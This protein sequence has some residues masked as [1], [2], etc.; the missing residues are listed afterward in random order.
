MAAIESKR[1]VSLA[2]AAVRKTSNRK[3]VPPSLRYTTAKHGKTTVRRYPGRTFYKIEEIKGKTIDL[4]EVFLCAE[5]HVID[6]RFDD[7]TSLSF[8]I[9]PAFTLETEHADWKTG[10]WRPSRNG[11]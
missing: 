1:S 2:Q 9:E 5:Y 6:M 10:D 11:L 7:K 3:N 4:V 8:A